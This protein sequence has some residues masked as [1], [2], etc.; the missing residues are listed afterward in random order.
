MTPTENAENK[1]IIWDSSDNMFSFVNL[2]GEDG[3]NTGNLDVSEGYEAIK[4]SA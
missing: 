3:T 1:G 4:C 2:S